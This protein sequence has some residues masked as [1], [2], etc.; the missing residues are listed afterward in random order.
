M[1]TFFSWLYVLLASLCLNHWFL[2][3]IF[4]Y[5]YNIRRIAR[6]FPTVHY[7]LNLR[8]AARNEFERNME[9]RFRCRWK[10]KCSEKYG[11][12][13]KFTYDSGPTGNRTRAALVKGTGT[14][15][16]PTRPLIMHQAIKF[17]S[18]FLFALLSHDYLC[19][20]QQCCRPRPLFCL[21]V[22]LVLLKWNY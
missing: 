10:P 8:D 5:I 16:A 1:A 13:I 3:I 12:R 14:T 11:S 2:A 20:D 15:A 21:R 22:Q 19:T 4:I 9:R 7:A 6:H 18:T 17:S